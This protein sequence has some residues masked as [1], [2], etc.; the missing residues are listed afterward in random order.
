MAPLRYAGPGRLVRLTYYCS[1]LLRG[2]AGSCWGLLS[3]FP[4]VLLSLV[5]FPLCLFS[6]SQ[7][8]GEADKWTKSRQESNLAVLTLCGTSP[9]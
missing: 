9:N 1:F 7:E 6:P 3:P 5:S 8:T 2:T 4:P